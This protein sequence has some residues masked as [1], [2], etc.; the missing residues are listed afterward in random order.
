MHICLCSTIQTVVPITTSI[1]KSI[2]VQL[3]TLRPGV[4]QERGGCLCLNENVEE[5]E[6]RCLLIAG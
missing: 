4:I 3:L 1:I 2:M 6:E 5:Q